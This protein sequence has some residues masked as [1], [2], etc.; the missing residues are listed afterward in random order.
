MLPRPALEAAVRRAL[1]RSRGVVLVGPRQAGKSTLAQAFVR[2]D[3]PQYFDLEYPPHERRLAEPALALEQ[4]RGLVVIDEVQRRPDL[5]PLLRVLMDRS[6]APGQYLLLGSASPHLARQAGESLLGRVEVVEAAGFDLR[7]VLPRTAPWH[8]ETA[9]RLWL[10]G[11]FPRSW[12]AATDD[13]SFAWRQQAIAQHLQTDLPQFGL[14]ISAP[15]MLRFW[16][17]LTHYHGQTWSAA[18]PAR[19]LGVSEPTIRRYLDILTQTMMLRQLQPWHENLG[20]R[21]VKAPK[22]YFRDTGL[23]HALMDVRT[24]AQ[25]ATHPRAGAS[26]EG[27]AL[28]QVLRLAR[29]QQAY[30]WATHQGAELDLLMFQGSRRI[31]VEFKRAD[32]PAV[33]PSMRIAIDDLKLDALYVVHPG[34]HRFKMAE[35][36]EAVPLWAMLP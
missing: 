20:K 36:I 5:F 11:G 27:F 17:M 35:G 8:D 15:G 32:A 16:T 24:M 21:Q 10:R 31:G 29:P 7:E 25:L 1:A 19:S 18:D 6:D 4:A 2:R 12:L 30:F 9:S 22:L 33:T 28:E 3:S 34:Q 13:D 14:N 23:L 26:W